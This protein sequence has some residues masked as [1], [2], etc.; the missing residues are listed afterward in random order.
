MIQRF[1]D[2]FVAKIEER[3]ER[4]TRVVLDAQEG[5]DTL[6]ISYGITA[7]SAREA[8]IQA[9]HRNR[10]VS[11]LMILS[12]WPVPEKVIREA[13]REVKRVIVPEL[14]MGQYIL[15]VQRVLGPGIDVIGVN[16]MDTT[17]LSPD[18]ILKRLA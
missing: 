18:E 3:R 5:A 17:L 16:K 13:A 6:V 9:R 7:R 1:I 15:E 10:F 12:I 11:H 2:H 8:V 4:F 14:N